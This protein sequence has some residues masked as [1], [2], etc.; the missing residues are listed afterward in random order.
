MKRRFLLPIFA[1]GLLLT[2]LGVSQIANAQSSEDGL[3]KPS[4]EIPFE[5]GEIQDEE[6]DPAVEE[7]NLRKE[8]RGIE[9]TPEEFEQVSQ[10]RRQFRQELAEAIKNNYGSIIQLVFLPQSEAETQAGKVLGNPITNYSDAI[11]QILTPEEI[12]IWQQN[13]EE[14]AQTAREQANFET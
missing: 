9:L 13:M 14:D 8:F 5:E 10:A 12:K 2:S 11:S 7:R 1:T 6:S 3:I 4:D